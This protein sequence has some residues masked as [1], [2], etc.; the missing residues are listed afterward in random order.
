MRLV[1]KDRYGHVVENLTEVAP[2]PAH[3]IQLSIDERLQTI[4]EDALDNAVAWNKAESGASVLINIQT[5]EI[6][7]MASFP[8]FNPNNREGATLD[9]F[10]NRAISDTFEPGS[11]VKPLLL[12]TALQQGL[13]QPDSVIDTHPYTIDGHRIRDVGYYPELTMTG[14]LQK[15]S[16]TG[17][18]RLSLAMPVQRLLDTYK[19][20]GFGESTGL[21]LTGESAG[22]L[23]QRKFW[24]Q[25]DRATFAF[26]Y[27]LMVTPSSW[28]MCMPPSAAMA[29]NGLC[30]SPESIRR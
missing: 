4:T 10:R 7:A 11:T 29:L 15:S 9:D 26:G 20:F 8:D 30:P 2:V 22:L 28:R 16:D 24:S 19:H 5:G 3:N 18:S 25:L 17:V 21:G 6:L 12:M 13:V 23:P 27:G 1:R 14:I